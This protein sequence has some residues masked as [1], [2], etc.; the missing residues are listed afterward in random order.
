MSYAGIWHAIDNK[1]LT[2]GDCANGVVE[3]SL[4]K[5]VIAFDSVEIAQA[6][7]GIAASLWKCDERHV[8]AKRLRQGMTFSR[9][10]KHEIEKNLAK[11]KNYCGNCGRRIKKIHLKK[12]AG[13]LLTAEALEHGERVAVNVCCVRCQKSLSSKNE[14]MLECLDQQMVALRNGESV[15][16]SLGHYVRTKIREVSPSPRRESEQAANSQS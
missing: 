1:F 16:K 5:C 15:R 3:P 9:R 13:K 8:V 12:S 4:R 6:S 10:V 7:L 14:R 2:H 11:S